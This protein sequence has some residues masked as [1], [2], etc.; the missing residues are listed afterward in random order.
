MSISLTHKNSADVPQLS[1]T[2]YWTKYRALL[3]CNGPGTY[4]SGPQFRGKISQK[5]ARILRELTLGHAGTRIN[6]RAC[7]E[8]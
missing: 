5:H 4:V 3:L 2:S 8:Y 6:A 7:R 1:P